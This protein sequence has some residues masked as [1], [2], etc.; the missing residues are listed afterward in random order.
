[1][2]RGD[3][4]GAGSGGPARARALKDTPARPAVSRRAF[5][6]QATRLGGVGAL[7]AALAGCRIGADGGRWLGRSLVVVTDGGTAR[8]A[9][10]RA[11]F[12]P[13]ARETGC[14]VMEVDYGGRD[15]VAEL[16]RQ[17][18]TG[19]AQWD[20]VALDAIHVP[21]LAAEGLLAPLDETAIPR[22]GLRAG[23]ALAHAAAVLADSLV[24]AYRAEPF[25]AR[26]PVGW[27]D[28]WDVAA[29]PD[30]RAAPRDGVGLL[31]VAL[32]AD[33]LPPARLYPLDLDRAFRSL[34]RLRPAVSLW[35]R[36]PGEPRLALAEGVVDLALARGGELRRALADGADVRL[37]ALP[38][39]LLPVC[40]VLPRAAPNG[41]VA[42]DFI[43]YTLRPAVQAAVA[44]AGYV[45]ALAA[46][47]P[48][49]PA[50]AFVPD[51]AWWAANGRAAAARFQ[52]WVS[53]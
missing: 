44:A 39:P 45:P 4:T 36:K 14:G 42:S 25:R 8:L 17:A 43:A 33:G 37:P 40:W 29:F 12:V 48:A 46:H 5:L 35:W 26:P 22:V 53:R 6:R 21:A 31:E 13:F 41:D 10:W 47:G 1:M 30:P 24:P 11:A 49:P 19:Q 28:L 34:D 7:G 9:L 51:L 3:G 50:G 18:L 52:E 2:A 27:A 15:T 32:L 16:R 38:A 23:F 20:V